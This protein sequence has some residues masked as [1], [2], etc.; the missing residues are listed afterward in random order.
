V[1]THIEHIL[2]KLGFGSRLQV[3][4]WAAEQGLVV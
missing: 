3:G 2:D 1:A 4:L